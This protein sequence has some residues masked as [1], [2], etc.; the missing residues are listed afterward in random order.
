MPL[1]RPTYHARRDAML[2]ALEQQV[3]FVPGASFH[4]NG[5]GDNTLRLNFSRSSPERIAEGVARLGET[6]QRA[7]A[8][9]SGREAQTSGLS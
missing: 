3:A 5:G 6:L 9:F 1:I 4:A 8:D 2:S 7:A